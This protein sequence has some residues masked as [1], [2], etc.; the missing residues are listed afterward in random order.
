[1][2]T[3]KSYSYASTEIANQE[4]E[5]LKIRTFQNDNRMHM[6]RETINME[7]HNE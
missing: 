6:C 1:M 7:Y 5:T 4:I 2:V 3:D